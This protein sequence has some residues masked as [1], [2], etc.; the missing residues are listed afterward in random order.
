MDPNE[1]SVTT[2]DDPA[3]QPNTEETG[4][5]DWEKELNDAYA[6][7]D[8]ETSHSGDRPGDGNDSDNSGNGGNDAD[9]IK[10]LANWA[11]QQ[12]KNEVTQKVQGDIA[13]AVKTVE[14]SLGETKLPENLIRGALYDRVENDDNFKRAWINR[15]ANPQAW[16]RVLKAIGGEIASGMKDE[17][18]DANVTDDVNA[19]AAAV[20]GAST[21]SPGDG[22]G[23]MTLSQVKGMSNEEWQKA[24]REAG[25]PAYR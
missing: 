22:G 5:Q 11:R 6:A 23:Q 3:A 10:D 4:A 13:A 2:T 15:D 25:I 21:S 12:Q 24:Q 7:F 8:G 18:A 20:R 1:Q 19:V 16:D 9:D 17:K 14:G